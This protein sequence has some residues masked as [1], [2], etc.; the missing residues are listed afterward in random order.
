MNEPRATASAV[1]L[2]DPSRATPANPHHTSLVNALPVR[3]T[4]PVQRMWTSA[5]LAGGTYTETVLPDVVCM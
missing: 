5:A 2:L 3:R 1:D 4:L